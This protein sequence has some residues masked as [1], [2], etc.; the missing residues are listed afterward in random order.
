MIDIRQQIEERTARLE[1]RA[2]HERVANADLL[3][4]ARLSHQMT[5]WFKQQGIPNGVS[6]VYINTP[7]AKTKRLFVNLVGMR[8]NLSNISTKTRCSRSL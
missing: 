3:P 1:L 8:Q 6:F 5:E 2:D 7:L 4:V